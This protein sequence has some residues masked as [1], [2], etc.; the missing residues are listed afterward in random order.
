MTK[1]IAH[2]GSKGTHPENTLPTFEEAI[3][4]GADGIELDVHVSKDNELI[5]I[6]DERVDRTTNGEGEVKEMTLAEIKQLDA[7]SWF[8]AEYEGT[9]IPT[10]AEVLSFLKE[11]EFKGLLNIEIKT[12]IYDYPGIEEKVEQ[13]MTSES[14]PFI[15]MYSSFNFDTLTRMEKIAPFVPKA[16]IIFKKE[17]SVKKAQETDFIEGVHPKITWLEQ[18]SKSFRKFDKAI[19]P[20]TVNCVADMVMCYEENLAAIHTDFPRLAVAIKKEWLRE[21]AEG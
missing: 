11:R 6:H 21:K 20:W 10:L 12:D 19:R 15:Y 7:G 13:L 16:Y 14:W 3:V 17:A 5:V 18:P 2:R 1:I 9:T 4:A 8:D